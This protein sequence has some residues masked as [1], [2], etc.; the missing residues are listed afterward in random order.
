MI[1]IMSVQRI[2]PI[3]KDII[4]T[5]NINRIREELTSKFLSPFV[6]CCKFARS[7]TDRAKQNL[8]DLG[9]YKQ[10][11]FCYIIINYI[12]KQNLNM[13]QSL[14]FDQHFSVNI[15]LLILTQFNIFRKLQISICARFRTCR[16]YRDV[17]GVCK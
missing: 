16:T 17:P 6:G 14:H 9:K 4:R 1:L 8:E 12:I 3:L 11:V 13:V 10:F 7:W 2:V 5:L 15:G